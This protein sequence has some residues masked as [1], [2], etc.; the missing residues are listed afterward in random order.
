MKK[1]CLLLV[2]LSILTPFLVSADSYDGPYCYEP[3][4]YTTADNP[5]P[6]GIRGTC[7]VVQIKDIIS[8]DPALQK[9]YF[10]G[11]H[12]AIGIDCD[13][14]CADTTKYS[15]VLQIYS[16]STV[17]LDED[18][19]DYVP[20]QVAV[21]NKSFFLPLFLGQFK[22]NNLN[23]S[24][25]NFPPIMIYVYQPAEFNKIQQEDPDQIPKNIT[26]DVLENNGGLYYSLS[27]LSY[28]EYGKYIWGPQAD[29]VESQYADLNKNGKALTSQDLGIG[30]AGSHGGAVPVVSV[31]DPL[32]SVTDYWVYSQTN[33]KPSLSW[34]KTEYGLDD[35]T[36]KTVAPGNN[37]TTVDLMGNPASTTAPQNPAAQ[38]PAPAEKNIFQKIWDFILSWF[39]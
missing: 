3:K 14:E 23:F 20:T 4:S 17:I 25:S 7:K 2:A 38:N 28:Q 15:E 6:N 12:G 39:K 33:G 31:V 11:T 9:D 34:Q 21:F 36:V 24:E 13:R 18:Q 19:P 27:T 26:M 29:V 16:S 5:D 10:I 30:Y 37:S 22:Q 8:L 1:I 32:E 35:G